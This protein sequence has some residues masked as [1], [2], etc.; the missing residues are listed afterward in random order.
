MERVATSEE[1]AAVIAFLASADARFVTGTII[2]VDGGLS[3]SNG[4][5]RM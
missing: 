3:A 4:Q 1:V 5:P 2:P